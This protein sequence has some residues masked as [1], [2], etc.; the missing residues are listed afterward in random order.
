MGADYYSMLNRYVGHKV[1]LTLHGQTNV[2]GRV[3]AIC[4]DGMRLVDATICNDFDGALFQAQ[5]PP[6][7]G[8]SARETL[9]HLNQVLTVTCLDD[10]L[11][12][13][14]AEFSGEGNLDA[15]LVAEPLEL[16]LGTA[17]AELVKQPRD[18]GLMEQLNQL[19]LQIAHDLGLLLP[20]MRISES[21]R[22]APGQYLLKIRGVTASQGHVET[23]RL[24]ALRTSL[25]S[26]PLEGHVAEEQVCGTPG[27][28][29]ERP[30][31]ELAE[32]YGYLVLDAARLLTAQLDELFRA[33][34]ADLFGRQQLEELL[35]ECRLTSPALVEELIPDLVTPRQLQKILR[36]LLREGVPVRDLETILETLSDAAAEIRDIHESTERVRQ[37][38]APLLGE[39]FS[40]AQGRLHVVALEPT[41]EVALLPWVRETPRGPLLMMTEEHHELL[42]SALGERLLEL[43]RRNFPQ[44]VLTS[45]RLRAA[46]RRLT[47]TR[48]PKCVVL[49]RDELAGELTCEAEGMVYHLQVFVP[50]GPPKRPRRPRA[51]A[52]PK[53]KKLKFT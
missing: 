11:P 34:A 9:I 51:P 21:R 8:I 40:D 19:R 35:E 36:N 47:E 6:P 27:Y 15:S 44:V 25:A 42:L 45:P 13:Q 28:W 46:L 29:I 43:R 2:W 16:Q 14:N 4:F 53:R 48:F 39:R 37:A 22:L 5:Q 41:L 1:C 31:R 26:R 7:H 38:L 18:S 49:S 24:L 50:E 52:K 32:H 12:E 33:R 3:A 30:H 23:E 20:A 17:L 10:D